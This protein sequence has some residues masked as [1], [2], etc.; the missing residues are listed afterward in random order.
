MPTNRLSFIFSRAIAGIDFNKSISFGFPIIRSVIVT[1]SLL[2][3]EYNFVFFIFV[4][5]KIKLNPAKCPTFANNKIILSRAITYLLR[6]IGRTDF[7]VHVV[8]FGVFRNLSTPRNASGFRASTNAAF[9][10]QVF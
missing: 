5:F 3:T 9:V 4:N 2:S 1:G 10:V 7:I 6:M 8:G